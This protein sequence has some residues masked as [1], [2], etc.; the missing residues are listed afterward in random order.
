MVLYILVHTIYYMPLV[1]VINYL[2]IK[3]LLRYAF[4]KF[5]NAED[6]IQAYKEKYNLVIDSR[7]VVLRFRRGKGNVN[8]PGQVD[9]LVSFYFLDKI[10]L[11][12]KITLFIF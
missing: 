1:Q 9:K 2:K 4:I 5:S 8:P 7:S 10:L 3:F 12:L 6:A 11:I